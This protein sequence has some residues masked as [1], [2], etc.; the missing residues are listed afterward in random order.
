[1][2]GCRHSRASKFFLGEKGF[3]KE[4]ICFF[5][6]PAGRGQGGVPRFH[7]GE[8]GPK[9]PVGKTRFFFVQAMETGGPGAF[10]GGGTN[11]AEKPFSPLEREKPCGAVSWRPFI[12][13]KRFTAGGRGKKNQVFFAADRQW[14][15][16]KKR[17]LHWGP[18]GF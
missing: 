18:S 13:R 4:K 8:P 11:H 15:Y 3:L 14:G 7:G 16:G 12:G 10:Y 17:R 1:M 2:V 9:A 5:L 6:P